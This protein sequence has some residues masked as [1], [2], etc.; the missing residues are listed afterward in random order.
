VRASRRSE[1]T[2]AAISIYL[3]IIFSENARPRRSWPPMPAGVRL[4]QFF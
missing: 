3:C 1:L 2:P 4:P